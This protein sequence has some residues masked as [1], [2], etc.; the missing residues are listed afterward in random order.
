VTQ[1]D[2]GP[3]VFESPHV[4]ALM[5]VGQA[6][7]ALEDEAKAAGNWRFGQGYH[8]FVRNEPLAKE[9]AEGAAATI[10]AQDGEAWSS[11]LRASLMI[12]QASGNANELKSNVQHLAV[13]SL[14]WLEDIQARSVVGIEP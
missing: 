11:I 8:D 1:P 4:A 3:Y 5:D 10:M 2:G 9:V 12:A 7:I 6:R 14:A 13:L